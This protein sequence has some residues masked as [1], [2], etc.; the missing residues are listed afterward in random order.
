M[1]QHEPNV[2]G[3]TIGLTVQASQRLGRIYGLGDRASPAA[4]TPCLL[5][6]ESDADSTPTSIAPFIYQQ[7][8]SKIPGTLSI[9]GRLPM[10]IPFDANGPDWQVSVGHVLPPSM[11]AA[12]TG[13]R[14]GS[15]TLLPITWQ[16]MNH[17]EEL[18]N[19]EKEPQVVVLLDALQ[20][21]NQQGTLGK[22][23]FTIRQQFSSA[24]IWCPGIS[25]PDNLALLTWMGV[26]LHDLVRTSQCEA[27]N[28]LL[29][30]SGPRRTEE[31]LDEV[32]DRKTHLAI[33]KAELAT[34]RRAIRDGTLRELVEQ[35]VL[36]S[37]RMVEHLRHHDA[38]L[39]IPNQK[40][41]LQSVVA[42][43]RRF[44]AHSQASFNDPEIV[45]WVR[46]I[47]DDYCSP[48]ERDKVLILLPCSDRKP[49]R[50]SRSH[51]RFGHAIG[52][53]TAHEVMVTSPLGLVPRD[54]ERIWPAAHYDVPVTGDWSTEELERIQS[55]LNR[56][57]ENQGYSHVINHSGIK[58]DI[59]SG[60]SV[61]DSRLD[62]GATS[63][64]AFERLQTAVQEAI[65]KFELKGRSKYVQL[66]EEFRSVA[67]RQMR[68]DSWLD[69]LRVAG[70]PPRWKVYDG[71]KQIAQ[72]L[73]D[74]GAL[75]MT[76][77]AL[78][79]LLEGNCLPKI[80]LLEGIKW[81]GDV[82]SSILESHDS[83]IREGGE[84]LVL[85]G[86]KLLGSARASVSAWGWPNTPGKLAKGHQRL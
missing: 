53:T 5:V 16:R 55:M 64:A 7:D 54:L 70:K 36:S 44:R 33:W 13:D 10:S 48:E 84:L 41:V 49:Y 18:L 83:D 31:S 68:N 4:L 23:L 67:R 27:H 37:P 72:W 56:L 2:D 62:D 78:P 15:G 39:A 80:H 52:N 71:E 20:L 86:G 42:T 51:I 28:A 50:E 57:I 43:E 79:R 81:R 76:K 61:V 6:E 73:P 21:A 63:Q 25:G 1:T 9:M 45:D 32:V 24:L 19:L 74:R 34:V 35:R 46:F 22:A 59:P 47:S 30:N 11:V 8:N 75:S 14:G 26:D 65:E 12:D 82:F 58:L 77:A 60:I 3:D 29:T 69:G 38:L 66:M 85:Q 17:D 40:T